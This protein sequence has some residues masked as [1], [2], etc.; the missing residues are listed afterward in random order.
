MRISEALALGASRLPRRRGLADPARE[1]AWLLARATGLSEAR[2]RTDPGLELD[3]HALVRYHDWVERRAAGEPAHHLSGTCP[4]W[5]IELHVSPAVLV[6]RPETELLVEAALDLPLI[7]EPISDA[8][9]APIRVLDI[10]TGSGCILVALGLERP[11]WVLAG[12]DRSAAALAVARRNLRDAGVPALLWQGD[13]A[14][15][16]RTRLDLIVANL[17]Y[18]PSGDLADLP[19]EVQHDPVLALDGGPDGLD[20]IARL[21]GR[22]GAILTG[23]GHAVLE[24][25]DDQAGAVAQLAAAEG[26][27]VDRRVR[28]LGGVERVLVL[29]R[30]RV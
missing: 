9:D 28:D 23:H 7:A 8:G 15:A 19:I 26:L 29:R 27:E 12:V 22:L 14:A 3:E 16:T 25:G 6:P 11:G 20:L 21:L 2:V 10:G 18:I 1:A 5:G 24:I 17:P 4:F 30:R 13:L